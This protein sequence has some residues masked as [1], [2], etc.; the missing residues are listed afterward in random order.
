MYEN[1]TCIYLHAYMK[2]PQRKPLRCT[3]NIGDETIHIER[4]DLIK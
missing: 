4:D 3:N 1:N 2:I